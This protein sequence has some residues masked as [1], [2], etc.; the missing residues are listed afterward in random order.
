MSLILLLNL[1]SV[2]T[3]ITN[4]LLSRLLIREYS[5]VSSLIDSSKNDDGTPEGKI[6]RSMIDKSKD[7]LVDYG[8]P[9]QKLSTIKSMSNNPIFK[10]KV[11]QAIEISI[12]NKSHTIVQ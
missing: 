6:N 5:V 4:S 7:S 9:N 1:S 2:N 10:S 8:I 3:N 12:D 11:N